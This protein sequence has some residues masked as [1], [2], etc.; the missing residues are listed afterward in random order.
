[1]SDND[2]QLVIHGSIDDKVALDGTA[3]AAGTETIDG[4]VYNLHT[5]D[6]DDTTLIIAADIDFKT[7]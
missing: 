3:T 5:L 1:M 4:K 7:V 6:S 2:S